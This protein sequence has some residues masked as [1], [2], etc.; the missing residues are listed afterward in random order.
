MRAMTIKLNSTALTALAAA[1]ALLLGACA[2]SSYNPN[3]TRD[4]AIGAGQVEVL[5]ELRLEHADQRDQDRE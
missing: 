1:S 5:R 4:T 2:S 3:P